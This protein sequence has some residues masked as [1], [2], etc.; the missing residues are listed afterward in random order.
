[1]EISEDGYLSFIKNGL[2]KTDRPKKVVI[3]G[4]GMAGL[5]AA[6]ELL[7]AGHDPLVLEARTR[8]GGRIQTLREPFTHGLYGEAGAMRLPKNHRLVMAYIEKFGLTVSPFTMK[9]PK[10]FVF[11]Q[12]TKSRMA[13]YL[14]NPDGL[15]F[16]LAAHERGFTTTQ[17]WE[18]ALAPIT[19][20][21]VNKGD[22]AWAGIYE[23]F[24]QYSI[25][26]FLEAGGWSE[27][28]IELFG[29]LNGYEARMNVSFLDILHAEIGHS[30]T[31][32][33]RIDGGSDTLPNAFLPALQNRIRFGARLAAFDQDDA[34]VTM[35]YETDAGK[36][37]A[38]GDYA[39]ITIPFSVLGHVEA[40]KPLSRGKQKAIRQ[41]N[42]DASS[43]VFLQS[44]RRFWEEDDGIFGGGTVADLAI[45]NCYYPDHG[46]ETGR[47]VIL[48]SYT[49]AEDAER[50]GSLS[51]EARIRLA[52]ENVERFHP[53]IVGEFE[54][55][56]SK[57]WHDDD[58]AGGAFAL[59]EPGQK[60][61]L[62]DSIVSPEG[63][64]H[65]AGEHCSLN[66]RWIQG[67]VESGLRAGAVIASM[68]PL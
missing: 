55:G 2:P 16:E 51:P 39:I 29:L 20:Q 11:I 46:R 24:G 10:A 8:V 25:R 65:F 14:A 31:E 7:R 37:T 57:I 44:R 19:E 40:L 23:L 66:H 5:V 42:Y 60:A 6:Y 18:R 61:L 34:S 43:K 67:A 64:I 62:Y 47:G 58:C 59:F 32:V 4:A 48:A 54:G 56:A 28:A 9:N 45:R 21:L 53:Q 38:R 52:V 3:V 30:F 68:P 33:V 27:G 1:M 35:H 41:I 22:A 15:G 63:R 12:G 50:W 17:L 26:E 49:W 13:D 36:F